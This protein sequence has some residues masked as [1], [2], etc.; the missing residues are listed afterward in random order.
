MTAADV[1]SGTWPACY[2]RREDKRL[3]EGCGRYLADVD[4][5]GLLE[6]AFVRSSVAHGVVAAVDLTAVTGAPGVVSAYAAEELSLPDIPPRTSASANEVNAAMARPPLAR[7]RVR[8]VGEPLAVVVAQ[9]G[10]QAVDAAEMAV[11]DIKPLEVVADAHV[12]LEGHTA[13][14]E[15]S[16]TNVA[17]RRSS[18]GN[19]AGAAEPADWPVQ[20]H[21]AIRHPRLAPASIEPLGVIASPHDGRLTVWCGHQAPHRLRDQ[22]AEMLG[23]PAERVRVIVPDIGGGFGLRM[24]FYPEY[25]VV[26]AAALRLG[27]PV[28]WVAT[29]YENFLCGTH[30]RDQCHDVTLAGHRDGRI[31]SYDLRIVADVGAYPH[32]GSHVPEFTYSM[33]AGP[34]DIE[35]VRLTMTTVVSNRAPTGVYRGAG[36]PEATLSL[37][38]AVDEFA[39][40][41]GLDPMEVRKKN[42]IVPAKFPF[43]NAGGLVYDSGNYAAALDAALA[44]IDLPALREEQRRRADGPVFPGLGAAAF[45]D[46]SGGAVPTL[47]EYARAELTEEGGVRLRVGSSSAGQGHVTV[48]SQVA[49]AVF[50]CA[51]DEI[52]VIA[53]DTGRVARGVGS[54]ASRSGQMAGSAIRI[55]SERL[56]QRVLHAAAG[57]LEMASD[58]LLI[59]DGVVWA[60]GDP[61]GLLPLAEVAARAASRGDPLAEEEVFAPN[62]FTIPFGV[63]LAVVEVDTETGRVR[64]RQLIAAD[65][66]GNVLNPMIVEG[67]IHGSLAQGVHHRVSDRRRSPQATRFSRALRPEGIRRGRGY[68][69]LGGEARQVRR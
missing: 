63:D 3:L 21:L 35:H 69:T 24:G 19:E 36:R 30:G 2:L 31:H 39:R 9:S 44:C 58:D 27:R 55:A 49:A 59:K 5:D 14:F 43:R 4:V 18:A 52:E 45:V 11:A 6:C 8:Y 33:G 1:T 53:G 15:E 47:V 65:D 68:H 67:Q 50:Q 7:T 51:N 46:R 42:F 29:R 38:R 57:E 60:R 34:Y 16:A 10:A 66:C 32:N 22:M 12:A 48:W 28:R 20:V 23:L 17:A 56:Y 54:F 26:A 40:A 62:A 13:L 41:A 37:E 64:I 25:L 61:A